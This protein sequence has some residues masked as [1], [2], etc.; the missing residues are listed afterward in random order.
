MAPEKPNRG[1]SFKEL[2]EEGAISSLKESSFITIPASNAFQI[3]EELL[4]E[5]LGR[6]NFDV[7][8][9]QAGPTATALAGELS[10]K[11]N[12]KAYDVGTFNVSIEKAFHY[13]KFQF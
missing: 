8:F 9:I 4:Q 1:K 11:H 6:K 5:I 3:Y 7:V 10:L 13:L 2:L 12:I